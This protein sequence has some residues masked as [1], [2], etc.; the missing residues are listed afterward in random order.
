M[1]DCMN[2]CVKEAWP[3]AG[4]WWIA[5][6]VAGIVGIIILPA[7]ATGGASAAIQAC[8]Q[9]PNGS[10]YWWPRITLLLMFRHLTLR[11]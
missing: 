11:P 3:S 4:C 2:S 9:P 7:V 6:V 8:H 1:W 10:I 5:G